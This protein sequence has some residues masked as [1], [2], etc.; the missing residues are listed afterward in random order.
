MEG[1][2]K[3]IASHGVHASGP[4]AALSNTNIFMI[5]VLISDDLSFKVYE[6]SLM[7][8]SEMQFL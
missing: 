8:T 4:F 3:R 2:A 1:H 5:S 7:V 6:R